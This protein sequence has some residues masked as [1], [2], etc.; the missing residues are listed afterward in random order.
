MPPFPSEPLDDFWYGEGAPPK[1]DFA[2]CTAT[3]M[4]VHPTEST[5]CSIK[6]VFQIVPKDIED[7]AI[8]DGLIAPPTSE[9]EPTKAQSIATETESITETE[10]LTLAAKKIIATRK[11][12]KDQ[13]T[14]MKEAGRGFPEREKEVIGRELHL[15][16]KNAA[17]TNH[18]L[19]SWEARSIVLRMNENGLW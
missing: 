7:I 3:K 8:R 1:I 12:L 18:D 19:K 11:F 6:L 10:P 14:L 4:V 5:L 13:H 2:K 15:L 9:V 16:L 17:R